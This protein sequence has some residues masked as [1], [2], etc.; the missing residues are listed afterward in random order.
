MNLKEQLR[1]IQT[2]M[3]A[4]VDGAKAAG[5]DVTN[6]ELATLEA[7]A[8]EAKALK[9]KIERAEKSEALMD[10]IGGKGRAADM[11]GNPVGEAGSKSREWALKALSNLKAMARPSE[12]RARRRSSQAP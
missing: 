9:A 8:E 3:Q 12:R 2:A 6:A 7:K 10:Y 11:D 1:A 4:I 5:R